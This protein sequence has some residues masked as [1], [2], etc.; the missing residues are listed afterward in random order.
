MLKEKNR[1][2]GKSTAYLL[3]EIID[4]LV[5]D[6]LHTSRRI[7]GNLD[8]IEDSVFDENKSAARKI[9]LLRREITTLKRLVNPLKR[10]VLET[11]KIFKDF[12]RLQKSLLFILMM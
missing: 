2:M 8:D 5:D 12:Q 9:S 6:L 4:V 10:I 11:E 3:H 7:D 1:L